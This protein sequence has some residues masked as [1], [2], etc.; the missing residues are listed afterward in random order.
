[1]VRLKS[2]RLLAFYRSRDADAVYKSY[3]DDDG[4]TWSEPE[5][6]QLP[7]NN[8]GVQ[9]AMLASGTIAI[10]FNNLRGDH[11][12]WPLSVALSTDEGYTWGWVRDLEPERGR[13]GGGGDG[14][15][16]G[17]GGGGGGGGEEGGEE[18]LDEEAGGM[19][20]YSYPSL[21]EHPRGVI[22]VSYTFRRETV[23]YCRI[24]EAWIRAGPGTIG[25]YKPPPASS[26][27]DG[28]GAAVA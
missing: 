3:S 19:G 18:R 10:V 1:M 21:V 12:R 25:L 16:G 24:S 6:T 11:G 23:R 26:A 9:A 28:K 2:G 13:G 7:N 4:E 5:K 17:E 20:E 15:G 27:G 14:S 22:H 8:S